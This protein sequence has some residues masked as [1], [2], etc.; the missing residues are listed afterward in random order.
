[1]SCEGFEYFNTVVRQSE[2]MVVLMS[3]DER[4]ANALELFPVAFFLT[5]RKVNS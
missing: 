2:M 5:P 4:I 3:K 1:M